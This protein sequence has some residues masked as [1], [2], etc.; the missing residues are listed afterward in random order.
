MADHRDKNKN[1]RALELVLRVVHYWW[2]LYDAGRIDRRRLEVLLA[3][4][5]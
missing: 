5:N 2:D 1:R 3:E 4:V